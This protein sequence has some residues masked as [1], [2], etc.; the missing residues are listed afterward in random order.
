MPLDAASAYGER[1]DRSRQHAGWGRNTT[2]ARPPQAVI[3]L[4]PSSASARGALSGLRVL[5][6]EMVIKLATRSEDAVTRD[7]VDGIGLAKVKIR[8][9]SFHVSSKY[10]VE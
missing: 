10:F 9:I 1:L 6:R 7:A 8:M 4:K 2:N 5:I 3:T